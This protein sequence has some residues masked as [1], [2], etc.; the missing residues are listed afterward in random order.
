MSGSG[1]AVEF[2]LPLAKAGQAD[3]LGQLLEPYRNYLELLARLQIGRRLQSKVDAA[4]LVQET[5]LD[6]H[7]TFAEFRGS[8]ERELVGWL[9]QVLAYNLASLVRR[10]CGTRRRNVE[11]ERE[12]ARELDE[13]S[14]TLDRGFVAANSSPSQQAVRRE[15]AVLLADALGRLPADYREVIIL[16]QLEGLSFPE[17]ARQM[18]RSQESVKKLWVR[19]LARLRG[20]L[21]EEP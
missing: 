21:G 15:Q 5:F 17:V 3:A 11:L 19:G 9:R 18:K 2:L 1:Q 8:T 14:Q 16:R 6:A 4:D 20:A 13:S 10:Y 12:L 7:A